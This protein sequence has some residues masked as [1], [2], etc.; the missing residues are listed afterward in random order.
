MLTMVPCTHL[1]I[2]PYSQLTRHVVA[3]VTFP[4]PVING[5]AGEARGVG[6][7]K[8]GRLRQYHPK[9]KGCSACPTGREGKGCW[10]NKTSVHNRCPLCARHL[11]FENNL[12]GHLLI[13]FR[14][15]KNKCVLDNYYVQGSRPHQCLALATTLHANPNFNVNICSLLPR[16]SSEHG[17]PLYLPMEK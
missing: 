14:S 9:D 12:K 11:Q 1:W 10:A 4:T 16:A 7:G 2:N 8:E 3:R 5:G 15:T 17:S 13:T 6:S